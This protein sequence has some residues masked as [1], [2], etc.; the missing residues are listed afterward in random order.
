MAGEV[1]FSWRMR[2]GASREDADS[3]VEAFDQQPGGSAS[4]L[5]GDAFVG[6]TAVLIIAGV[7]GFSFLASQIQNLVCKSRKAGVVIDARRDPLLIQEVDAL[8]GGT[9]VTINAEGKKETHD[10]CATG[11]DLAEVIAALNPV[12]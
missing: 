8:P 7:A 10:A 6:T 12:G 5:S 1:H 9:V 2:K 11:F 4:L 3:I